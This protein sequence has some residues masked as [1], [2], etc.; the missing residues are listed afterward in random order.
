M[1]NFVAVRKEYNDECLVKLLFKLFVLISI[2]NAGFLFKLL[3][4]AVGDLFDVGKI[5]I[6]HQTWLEANA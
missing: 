3:G 4:R 2:K 5:K 1:D 6:F